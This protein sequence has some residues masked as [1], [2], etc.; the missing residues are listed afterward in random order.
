MVLPG[1]HRKFAAELATDPKL[2]TSKLMPSSSVHL[3]KMDYLQERTSEEIT[4]GILSSA[5]KYTITEHCNA[6]QLYPIL[7]FQTGVLV[8]SGS[9]GPEH[10]QI[11]HASVHPLH[12]KQSFF[13]C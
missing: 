7:L 8:L 3:Q 9:L 11:C 10:F 2:W 12:W 13:L 1:L 5:H 4:E 6:P